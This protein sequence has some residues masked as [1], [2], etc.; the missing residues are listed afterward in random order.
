MSKQQNRARIGAMQVR[1]KAD[2]VNMEPKERVQPGS[3][4]NPAPAPFLNKLSGV[5]LWLS[6]SLFFPDFS[7]SF[8]SMRCGLGCCHFQRALSS[9][10]SL[11]VC[12]LISLILGESENIEENLFDSSRARFF[13]TTLHGVTDTWTA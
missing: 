12:V 1:R 2:T 13:G 9:P 4:S 11:C 3:H 7:V 10:C 8:L 6:F 5:L